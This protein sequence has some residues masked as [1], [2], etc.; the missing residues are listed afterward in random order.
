ME[1]RKKKRERRRRHKEQPASS[2]ELHGAG[3][4]ER[5]ELVYQR[6]LYTCIHK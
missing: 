1:E 2:E 4:R 5:T 3:E 6:D